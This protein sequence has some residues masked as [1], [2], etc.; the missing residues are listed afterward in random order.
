MIT[1][2]KKVPGTSPIMSHI[3]AE[4]SLKDS[5]DALSSLYFPEFCFRFLYKIMA[6]EIIKANI[7]MRYNSKMLMG[8]SLVKKAA[9]LPPFLFYFREKVQHP[10]KS[11]I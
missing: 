8:F 5:S 9:K 11:L 1:D 4:M 2:N 10:T 6:L 7:P 3:F